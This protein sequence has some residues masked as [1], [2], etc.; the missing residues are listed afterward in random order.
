MIISFDIFFCYFFRFFRYS[1]WP[2]G[3]L[4]LSKVFKQILRNACTPRPRPWFPLQKVFLFVCLIVIL[5]TFFQ[6][7]EKLLGAFL[8]RLQCVDFRWT[9]RE[10][11]R[12]GRCRLL[13]GLVVVEYL[14]VGED[15]NNIRCEVHICIPDFSSNIVFVDFCTKIEGFSSIK[16]CSPQSRSLVSPVNRN[17]SLHA[18]RLHCNRLIV[19]IQALGARHD[20]TIFMGIFIFR[21]IVICCGEKKEK[22]SIGGVGTSMKNILSSEKVFH[23]KKFLRH[24]IRLGE[25]LARVNCSVWRWR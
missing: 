1:S 10:G 9:Y 16:M 17:I 23:V 2:S 6:P 13:H 15:L 11:R 5:V 14:R 7:F 20:V 8:V 3:I 22:V 25:L 4:I 12:L 19:V 24:P 21:R 18:R